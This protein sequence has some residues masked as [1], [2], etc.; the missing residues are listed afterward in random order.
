[1]LDDHFTGIELAGGFLGAGRLDNVLGLKHHV[2]MRRRKLKASIACSAMNALV[3]LTTNG[4]GLN[5]SSRIVAT[6]Y[7]LKNI[8]FNANAVIIT[9]S[10]VPVSIPR[11]DVRSS[12]RCARQRADNPQSALRLARSAS[13]TVTRSQTAPLA[14]TIHVTGFIDPEP[15]SPTRRTRRPNPA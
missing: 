14:A 6:T 10:D 8:S 12:S 3:K 2:C 1:V 13:T 7:T 9:W 11:L 4:A 15:L 5:S